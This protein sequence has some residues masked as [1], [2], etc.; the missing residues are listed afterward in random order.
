MAETG[1][2]KRLSDFFVSS[3]AVD[4]ADLEELL[5]E[6]DSV[7]LEIPALSSTY[8]P[9]TWIDRNT[10]FRSVFMLTRKRVLILKS[11]SGLNVLRDIE[12]DAVVRHRFG[13]AR[14]KGLRLE[15]KTVDAE[16]AIVFHRQ[17]EK[18]F[19]ELVEKFPEALSR[20]LESQARSGETFFCMHCGAK[21]PP[22]S[23]F[24]SSCGKKVKV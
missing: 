14:G 11:G 1:I 8:K 20:N 7:V 15:I 21:I 17:Y 6:D 2:W 12:L 18:R 9:R 19:E 10:F 16:D 3:P 5:G 22:Q 4:A 13:S 23:V 24:C